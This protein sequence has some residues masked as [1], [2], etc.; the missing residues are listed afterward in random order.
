[1]I[2]KQIDK[3]IK[4]A[5]NEQRTWKRIFDKIFKCFSC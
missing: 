3:N 2:S 5:E 1:M 4:T